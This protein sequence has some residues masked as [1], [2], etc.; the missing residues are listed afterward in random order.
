[1]TSSPATDDGHADIAEHAASW[2]VRHPM[3]LRAS[4]ATPGFKLHGKRVRE[5]DKVLLWFVSANRDE[6]N[7]DRP[8]ELDLLRA[9][10][11]HVSFGVK[12][13]RCA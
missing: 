8:F 12:Q 13:L 6:Q 7:L 4:A 11:R 3:P 5:G 10:N 2:P 1:M 9:P